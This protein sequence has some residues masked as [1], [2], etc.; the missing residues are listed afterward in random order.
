MIELIIAASV[1][2]G[3]VGLLLG[4]I[5]A[6]TA[7]KF[8]VES[9]PRIEIVQD[10][11]P[12]ANCGGCGYAGCADMAQAIVLK[13]ADPAKCPVSTEEARRKIAEA[14]GITLG[15]TE[16]KVAV[17]FCGG[18]LSRAKRNSR[19]N[20]IT[21]CRSASIVGGGDKA[22]RFGCLGYGSCARACPFGA[23]EMRD[24][25]AVVHPEICVG[26][27]KCTEVCPRKL[28]RLVSAAA[29]VHVYCN[30]L[31]KA[32]QKRKNCSVPCLVCKKCIRTDEM[33]MLIQN[34]LVRVNY[35]N[36]PDVSIVEK[37][38]CPTGCLQ[39]EESHRH[40]VP[41]A[42]EDKT[43][44]SAAAKQ[45]PPQP[46]QQPQQQPQGEKKESAA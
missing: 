46:P 6:F 40:L 22:C 42:V 9:D 33:H 21:D 15:D 17:V 1:A 36:P 20:G 10:L 30:S 12:G 19:Y 43:T 37:A 7:K 27:G 2:V 45:A 14:M 28:I 29:K 44:K 5:I 39:T 8:A 31:D 26:C 11:L 23:I 32:P 13:G 35:S 18:S 41:R 3:V 38:G 25:L 16:K 4:V 24:G 34:Q